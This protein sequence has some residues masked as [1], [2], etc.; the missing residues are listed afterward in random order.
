MK[1]SLNI[2]QQQQ[3]TQRLSP[4]QVQ[5]ARLL[6][7]TAPEVEEEVRRQLDDNPALEAAD[8]FD[9]D[10][11]DA[12]EEGAGEAGLDAIE[13]G[14]AQADA[15]YE[16]DKDD[17]PADYYWP[18]A[19]AVAPYDW[20]SVSETADL[21]SYLSSQLGQIE[22]DDD[23]RKIAL[24]IIGNIDENGYMTRG[25]QSMADDLAI[26]G[27]IDAT[28]EQ[29]REAFD[30][31][32]GLDPAGVGAVDLRDCLLLQLRRRQ[33]SDLTLRIAKEVVGDYFDMLSKK[34]YDRMQA[35]L[36]LDDREELRKALAL[37]R[38]L[39]PKPGSAIA[40]N[41]TAMRTSHITPDVMVDDLGDGR[42]SVSLAG[43][44]PRLQLER[45][46]SLDAE[47]DKPRSKGEREAQ[48]FIRL[49]HDEAQAF[50]DA[51]KLRGE[52]LLNVAQAIVKRQAPFFQTGDMAQ[53]RPMI[54]K[55][56]AADTGYDISVVSRS[57]AGK[58]M[59]TAMGVYAMKMFFGEA[60][61]EDADASAHE[62][63]DAISQIVGGEDKQRP[64]SDQAILEELEKRG[65]RMARRTITKYRE[66]L[67]LPVA[68]LRKED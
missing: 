58:Y 13:S 52:T 30:A 11:E 64:L 61:T 32:R 4:R 5:F 26:S 57:T 68:R 40:M 25:L 7:M 23:I 34:H 47:S 59:A 24:Y 54:L 51:I 60:P 65:Y 17:D 41:P 14:Y 45:T 46:F 43:R 37:I 2:H 21:Y 15:G 19:G 67:G 8:S 42:M 6:E 44:I 38:S 9:G 29:M 53:L 28:K 3:T 66:K 63:M 48:A 36:G 31:V 1:E 22:L 33:P 27:E 16:G 55:D 62:L 20:G 39:N 18:A 50:I 35:Q 49:K 10:Y 12:A 56:I